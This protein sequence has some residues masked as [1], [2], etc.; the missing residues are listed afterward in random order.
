MFDFWIAGETPKAGS[1][2]SA[3]QVDMSSFCTNIL[4][5]GIHL[6][7]VGWYKKYTS[8]FQRL[9]VMKIRKQYKI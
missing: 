8:Y 1:S 3:L 4:K 2:E 6:H 5:G 9:L 7:V